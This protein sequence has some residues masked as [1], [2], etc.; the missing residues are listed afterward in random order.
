MFAP[1]TLINDRY[2]LQDKLG[3]NL[4]RQ[5]WLAKDN[6]SQ[7]SVILKLLAF[8]SPM[9]W[10]D[11]TLFEREAA[12]LKNISHPRIPKYIEY[13]T[14]E[15]KYN[16]F[17]L[18]QSYIP[19]HSLQ[20]M[21]DRGKRFSELDLKTL[22]TQILEI[23]SYLHQLNPRVLHRDLKPSNIIWGEDNYIY[24]IDFGAVQIQAATP[25]KSFTVVGT[26]GYTPIEQFGGKTVPASDLYALGCT[27]IHLLT[28]IAPAELPQRSGKIYFRNLTNLDRKFIKWIEWLSDPM[29]DKRPLSAAIALHN[30]NKKSRNNK[31]LTRNI[32]KSI[33][34]ALFLKPNQLVFAAK[35][36]LNAS[37]PPRKSKISWDCTGE[38]LNI[39]IPAIGMF[40]T[41][42]LS[43]FI[44]LVIVICWF[45]PL[46]LVLLAS[47]TLPASLLMLTLIVYLLIS[48]LERRLTTIDLYLGRKYLIVAYKILGI[49]LN[50]L[51]LPKNKIT[52]LSFLVDRQEKK[53]LISLNCGQKKYLLNILKRCS[54]QEK[55]WITLIL[56]NWSDLPV[57]DKSRLKNIYQ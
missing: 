4:L 1:G 5:T 20:K 54:V 16:Y 34:N 15:E 26:Y 40:A 37:K 32:A 39:K 44:A 19:G 50:L 9:Q 17:V 41:Q 57:T 51:K 55:A 33:S 22:A 24:L 52:Q 21:L 48:D 3:D 42:D 29:V 8:G 36:G 53:G 46:F 43:E 31:S 11:L 6:Q 38:V 45:G 27:L 56:S 13:F 47:F 7:N 12:I 28:G 25:G 14:I 10:Q 2:T 35:F 49:N 30:L 23:L 18:V